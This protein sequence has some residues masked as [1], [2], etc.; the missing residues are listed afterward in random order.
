[1]NSKDEDGK[2][3]ENIS[4][5]PSIDQLSWKNASIQANAVT[6]TCPHCRDQVSLETSR[7]HSVGEI[8]ELEHNFIPKLSYFVAF[9]LAAI[10]GSYI[11]SLFDNPMFLWILFAVILLP[12]FKVFFGFLFNFFSPSSKL[13]IHTTGCNRCSRNIYVAYSKSRAALAGLKEDGEVE[14]VVPEA[15]K[16]SGVADVGAE[17]SQS[18]IKSP[19]LQWARAAKVFF[20]MLGV[21]LLLLFA[22]GLFVQYQ[23][24]ARYEKFITDVQSVADKLGPA[25]AASVTGLTR[26]PKV[27]SK[28]AAKTLYNLVLQIDNTEQFD[29]T[30]LFLPHPDKPDV[31]W[32]YEVPMS[33]QPDAFDVPISELKVQSKLLLAVRQALEGDPTALDK[34]N[35]GATESFHSV[36][37]SQRGK[38]VVVLR[39]IVADRNAKKLRREDCSFF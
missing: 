14:A 37:S 17:V 16:E 38:P 18:K 15:S 2:L 11:A 20:G 25:I 4:R 7:M 22:L 26:V 31:L 30:V 34:C 9:I 1:M 12:P 13:S 36:I 28:S 5:S 27:H 35:D 33:H 24:T 3:K 8:L 32:F 21:L 6:G 29:R 19:P 23:E 39:H 10:G